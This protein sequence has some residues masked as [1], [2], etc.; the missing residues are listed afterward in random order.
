LNFALSN[1]LPIQTDYAY[2]GLTTLYG[3]PLTNTS[4]ASCTTMAG[5][6]K[7]VNTT[8]YL[9]KYS[10][11]AFSQLQSLLS[12][13]PVVALIAVNSDFINYDGVNYPF[14]CTYNVTN[15]VQVNTA[16]SIIGYDSNSNIMIEAPGLVGFGGSTYVNATMTGIGFGK[17]SS[18][19]S[20]CGALRHVYQ[21][22]T[23]SNVTNNTYSYYTYGRWLVAG[24]ILASTL[25][26]TL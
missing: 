5:K 19:K 23:A 1:G 9:N 17:I 16:I 22:W 26:L 13:F 25:L 3:I 24:G 21:Y 15:D 7:K 8:L 11:I 6:L 12:N 14:N 18:I 10:N 2:T 4:G 20:Y